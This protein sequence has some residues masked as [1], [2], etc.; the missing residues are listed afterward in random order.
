MGP[1]KRAGSVRKVHGHLALAES[2]R[3]NRPEAK[4]NLETILE[5]I[6]R[7]R[8]CLFFIDYKTGTGAGVLNRC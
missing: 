5:W 1:A 4:E 8:R 3:E 7:P 6:P 2:Y